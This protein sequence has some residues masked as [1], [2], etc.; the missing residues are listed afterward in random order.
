V[1]S[2]AGVVVVLDSDHP[3]YAVSSA[4]LVPTELKTVVTA[5]SGRVIEEPTAVRRRR[6]CAS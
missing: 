5:A 4:H 1:M 2:D 3:F 6:A